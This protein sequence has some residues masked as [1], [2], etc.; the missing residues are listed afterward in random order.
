LRKAL[1]DRARE[2]VN[3]ECNWH[4]VAERYASFIQSVV[5][6]REWKQAAAA[7][8]V[9]IPLQRT[10]IVVESE[11]VFGWATDKPSRDYVKTHISRFEKTL[12]I[13]P[14]GS[15]QKRILEMGS[16]MQITPALRTKLGYGEVR[17]CYYGPRGKMDHKSVVSESGER[18]ECDVDLFDAEKDYFPYD[19]GYFDTVLCCELIEHLSNDP[20]FMMSEINRIL[21]TG[22]HLVL[23]TPNISSVRAISA[24]LQGY[25]PGFFPAYIK[26]AAP[27]EEVE[28]RH[29]REYAPREIAKL[30]HYSGFEL[31]RLETAEFR[32]EPHPDH[33]WVLHMLEQYKLDTSLRGDGIY[34]VGVK[35]GPVRE[36][37]PSWLY[38]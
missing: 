35:R 37:Y 31:S 6:G 7:A 16:Y 33:E 30:M 26:P 20:M 3:R 5:S 25:H 8:A 23:T 18:F 22:G 38:S 9:S 27:G 13:I 14:L 10:R 12:S 36:R 2:W 34:A 24:A 11:Y 4:S 17:G 29:A 28:A 15:P 1:G 32:E 21:K 19:N